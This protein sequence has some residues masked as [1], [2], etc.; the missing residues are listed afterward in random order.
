ME[1]RSGEDVRLEMLSCCKMAKFSR[2]GPVARERCGKWA[3][4]RGHHMS[5]EGKQCL[6]EGLCVPMCLVSILSCIS[7]S[8][9][10]FWLY[11]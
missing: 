1:A 11:R 4:V 5:A 6:V 8:M 9:F 3:C 2:C 10:S 7:I